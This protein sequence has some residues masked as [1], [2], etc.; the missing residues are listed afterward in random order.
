MN[1]LKVEYVD[2][3]QRLNRTPFDG[4]LIFTGF[5][6]FLGDGR[7][8]SDQW[9]DFNGSIDD[10]RIFSTEIDSAQVSSYVLA[11][12]TLLAP[13]QLH[14]TPVGSRFGKTSP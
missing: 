11:M 8:F 7:I 2:G 1:G 3:V 6:T 4:L 13:P 14:M 5:A 10:L 9:G 12:V